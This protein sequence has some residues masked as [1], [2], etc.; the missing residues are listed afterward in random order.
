MLPYTELAEI[1]N[2]S[3]TTLAEDVP[4]RLEMAGG[5]A[6]RLGQA[7]DFTCEAHI[8][9][10]DH[11][12]AQTNRRLVIDGRTFKVLSA[13]AQHFVPHLELELREVRGG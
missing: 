7:Y 3:G 12:V 9:A 11:L 6:T 4:V 2:Q 8:S 1:Q 10:E 5:N 13:E